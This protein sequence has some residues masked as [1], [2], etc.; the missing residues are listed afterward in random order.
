MQT[1]NPYKMYHGAYVPNWLLESN[2]VSLGAKLCFGKLM[3]YAG[4]DGQCFPKQQT[5]ADDLGVSVPSISNYVNELELVKLIMRK[6]G[7]YLFLKHPLNQL[8]DSEVQLQ[9]TKVQLQDSE[10]PIVLI[11]SVIESVNTPASLETDFPLPKQQINKTKKSV[12]HYSESFES[13]W[14]TYPARNGIKAG[15]P[16]A[17]KKFNKID[18][19]PGLIL[20]TKNYAN[21]KEVKEGFAK[22]AV[23]FL[24]EGV[25]DAWQGQRI[26]SKPIVDGFAR[27]NDPNYRLDG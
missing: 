17:Y 1:F 3:Q 8:Q 14:K 24:K 7:Y 5:L 9:D 25:W 2:I 23:R 22:D 21:S 4:R 13:W 27:Y 26:D 6:D 20:A 18:D 19:V 16:D 10:V 11:E 12:N 15:K